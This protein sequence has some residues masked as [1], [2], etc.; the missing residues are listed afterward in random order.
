MVIIIV[1]KLNSEVDPRQ[2]LGHRPSYINRPEMKGFR[3]WGVFD[4]Y[5]ISN[6]I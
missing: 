4:S 5:G 1:L 2:S 6:N 3:V